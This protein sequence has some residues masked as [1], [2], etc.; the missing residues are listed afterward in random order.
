MGYVKIILLLTV[1]CG[2]ILLLASLFGN[3]WVNRDGITF[4][5]W[6]ACTK[7]EC[8]STFSLR[9]KTPIWFNVCRAFVVVSC[10]MSIVGIIL[11]LVAVLKKKIKP[12]I[13]AIVFL[14]SSFFMVTA[15]AIY[16]EYNSI[17]GAG[18]YY[19][20]SY[21]C[22]WIGVILNFVSGIVGI[23]GKFSIATSMLK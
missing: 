13:P 4:G 16:T 11:T 9:F 21:F 12:I 6:K 8:K 17:N 22:G 5:L 14:L 18:F 1:L 19:G 10:F 20:W 2:C 15:L 7:T 23:L 3:D